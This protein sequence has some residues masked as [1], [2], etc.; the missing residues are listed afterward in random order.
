MFSSL[1]PPLVLLLVSFI[2]SALGQQYAGQTITNSLPSVTGA[3]KAFFNIKDANGGNTT[4]IN[5]FSLPTTTG[6]R[7]DTTKVQRAVIVLSGSNRDPW[8]YYANVFN[9]VKNAGAINSAATEESVAIIAPYFANEAVSNLFPILSPV[10]REL[11]CLTGRGSWIPCDEWRLGQLMKS[12][13]HQLFSTDHH[14]DYE[15]SD[16]ERFVVSSK[17]AVQFSSRNFRNWLGRGRYQYQSSHSEDCLL[18]RCFGPD[19]TIL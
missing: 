18:I 5:Y 16:L 4:L 2:P 1:F 13:R 8:D 6:K 7:Q 15:C 19:S 14:L 12:I 3:E 9:A 11:I 10:F 17:I